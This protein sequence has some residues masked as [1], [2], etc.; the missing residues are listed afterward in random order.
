MSE[1]VKISLP[2]SEKAKFRAWTEKQSVE[3]KKEIRQAVFGAITK[4]D[5]MAKMFAPVRYGFLRSSIQPSFASDGLGGSVFTHRTYAP[6]QEFGTGTKVVA[7]SDVAEYA[8]TFKGAGKRKVNLR[9]QPYLFPAFRLGT[10][11]MI[12]KL[13]QLGYNKK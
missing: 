3:V 1:F 11:E 13:E 7:P 10:K 5:R 6:Y 8:M 9:A 4:I 12:A 2:E